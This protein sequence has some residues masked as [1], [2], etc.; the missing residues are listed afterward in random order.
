MR[1]VPGAA[2]DRQRRPVARRGTGPRQGGHHKTRKKH[3]CE[4]RKRHHPRRALRKS[5]GTPRTPAQESEAPDKEP[6]RCSVPAASPCCDI[7]CVECPWRDAPAFLLCLDRY[8][9]HGA[10]LWRNPA[11]KCG[12]FTA[13]AHPRTRTFTA[14]LRPLMSAGSCSRNPVMAGGAEYHGGIHA[15]PVPGRERDTPPC[16]C[17]LPRSAG[18]QEPLQ[19]G[20]IAGGNGHR[21]AVSQ[22][23]RNHLP[24]GGLVVISAAAGPFCEGAFKMTE[25]AEKAG[26]AAPDIQS[27]DQNRVYQIHTPDHS[28]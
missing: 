28:H 26:I 10:R 24:A 17:G 14:R 3:Q 22:K 16:G 13:G 9:N 11:R 18:R 4:S 15:P 23:R 12:N 7:R 27:F 21:D 25:A 1:V 19:P 6:G 2:S 5:R 20:R 8:T